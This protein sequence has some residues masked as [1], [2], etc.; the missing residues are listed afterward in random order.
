MPFKDIYNKSSLDRAFTVAYNNTRD[1]IMN[2]FDLTEDMAITAITVAMDFGVD[3]VITSRDLNFSALS[4]A[5]TLAL[6]CNVNMWSC[7][8]CQVTALH[9]SRDC[10]LI[11]PWS[12]QV[13]EEC[14]VWCRWWMAIGGCTASCPSGCST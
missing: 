8:S 1:F 3:Q 13:F 4:R 10:L 5:L 11:T 2:A 9:R 7:G 6:N 14:A 12:R